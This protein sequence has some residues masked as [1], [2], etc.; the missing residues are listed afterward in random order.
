[1]QSRIV[2]KHKITFK[3]QKR[4]GEEKVFFFPYRLIFGKY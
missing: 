4:G 2:D 3:D 1:M